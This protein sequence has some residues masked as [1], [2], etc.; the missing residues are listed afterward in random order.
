MPDK[1]EQ[2]ANKGS[3]FKNMMA[4]L[5]KVIWPTKAQTAKS[6]C[7]VVLF[8]LIITAILVVLNIVF[9]RINISYWNLFTASN[10]TPAISASSSGE[11][12]TETEGTSASEE[13]SN[14]ETSNE[15]SANEESTAVSE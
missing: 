9:E 3:F 13:A 2:T 12:S 7:T 5:K 1:T 6:T 15:V 8:V 14:E 10:N 4:E 11:S